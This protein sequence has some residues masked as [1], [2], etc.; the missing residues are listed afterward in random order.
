MSWLRLLESGCHSQRLG[1][2]VPQSVHQVNDRLEQILEHVDLL[3]KDVQGP[4]RVDVWRGKYIYLKLFPRFVVGV[5][6]WQRKIDD[7]IDDGLH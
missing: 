7:S 2:M 6:Y 4:G 5:F 3:T 1:L